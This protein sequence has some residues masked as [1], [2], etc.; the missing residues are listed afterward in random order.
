MLVIVCMHDTLALSSW[1]LNTQVKPCL[2][3]PREQWHAQAKGSCKPC[4]TTFVVVRVIWSHDRFWQV[5]WP[6]VMCPL[7]TL[8][9]AVPK[10]RAAGLP[11]F[12]VA[13]RCVPYIIPEHWEGSKLADELPGA[14]PKPVHLHPLCHCAVLS[15]PGIIK[16]TQRLQLTSLSHMP[17]K[18]TARHLI[19]FT[20]LY[21]QSDENTCYEFDIQC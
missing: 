9:E 14:L 2:S 21:M 8:T 4:C 19:L 12:A 20:L 18:A 1:L 7:R 11:V 17:D 16:V 10:E 13:L 6:S 3:F 15:H 5:T